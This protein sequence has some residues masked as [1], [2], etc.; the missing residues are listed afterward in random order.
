MLC[1]RQLQIV[2]CRRAAAA[3]TQIAM[4]FGVVHWCV[5]EFGLAVAVCTGCRV[6]VQD[7]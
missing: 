2:A 4:N 1:V 6:V 7:A 5:D 3:L